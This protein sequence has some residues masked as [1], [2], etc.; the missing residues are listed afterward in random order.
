MGFTKNQISKG[1][2]AKLFLVSTSL[3]FSIFLCA[4]DPLFPGI[5]NLK[6]EIIVKDST[7]KIY[8]GSEWMKLTTTYEYKFNRIDSSDKTLTYVLIK[9][10]EAEKNDIFKGIRPEETHNF[11]K[12]DTLSS[13]NLKDSKGTRIRLEE[14]KGKI[15]VLYFCILE[16]PA[17][18]YEYI[19]LNDLM[20][21]YQDQQ[22]IVFIAITSEDRVTVKSFIKRTG[23]KFIIIPAARPLMDQYDIYAWPTHVVLDRKGKVRLHNMTYNPQLSVF[24]IKQSIDEIIAE[25]Q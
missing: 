11:K 3:L 24:W 19:E 2:R 13:F 4:Q 18:R 8:P 7:G 21:R 22:D 17:S 1:N 23:F 9:M 12:G 25:G 16:S 6:R 5:R 10:T 20:T 15:I 14:L